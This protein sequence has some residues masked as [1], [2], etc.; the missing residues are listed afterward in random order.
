MNS[1]HIQENN[2]QAKLRTNSNNTFID[3]QFDIH[4]RPGKKMFGLRAKPASNIAVF[5][6]LLL[7]INYL[8]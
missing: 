4:F 6:G 7:M 5:L 1:F 3:W 8:F 2:P